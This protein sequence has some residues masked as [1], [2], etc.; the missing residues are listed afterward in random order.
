MTRWRLIQN[1][2]FLPP[3]AVFFL[4]RWR[5]NMRRPDG[6]SKINLVTRRE[7]FENGALLLRTPLRRCGEDRR[8]ACHERR[9]RVTRKKWGCCPPRH[10]PSVGCSIW[11]CSRLLRYSPVQASHVDHLA[12]KGQPCHYAPNMSELAG[13]FFPWRSHPALPPLQPLPPPASLS[14]QTHRSSPFLAGLDAQ[15]QHKRAEALRALLR[16][17]SSA[18]HSPLCPLHRRPLRRVK[19]PLQIRTPPFRCA[20]RQGNWQAGGQPV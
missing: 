17:P 11:I 10:L 19:E 5:C 12:R 6:C 20:G 1:C 9:R 3:R 2:C 8:G 15:K 16:S 18:H 13:I 7:A 14:S 4:C